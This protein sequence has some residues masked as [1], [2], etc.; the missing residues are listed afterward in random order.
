MPRWHVY[1]VHYRDGS[2][3]AGITTDIIRRVRE[4]NSGSGAKY[5][6][7]RRLVMLAWSEAKRSE[8]CARK[9]REAAIKSLTKMEKE[10]LLKK[11]C[12]IKRISTRS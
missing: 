5:T 7:S 9:K 11:K 10:N 8:S 2:L 1:L 6:R 4:H 3:Y 12:P